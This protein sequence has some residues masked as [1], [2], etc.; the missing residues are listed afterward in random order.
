MCSTLQSRATRTDPQMIHSLMHRQ[1]DGKSAPE[2]SETGRLRDT[3][4]SYIAPQSSNGRLSG[5]MCHRN[6]GGLHPRPDSRSAIQFVVPRHL[7][8]G[9]SPIRIVIQSAAKKPGHDDADQDGGWVKV[10]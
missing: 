2:T 7:H 9:H 10:K 8:L 1:R 4:H 6:S 5:G 3:I